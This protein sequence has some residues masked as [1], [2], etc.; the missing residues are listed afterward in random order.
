MFVFYAEKNRLYVME[1]E[2]IT[3]GSANIYPVRFEFSRDWVRA[4]SNANFSGRVQKE[5]CAHRG[6]GVFRARR[7]AV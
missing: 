3:S 5:V 1:K 2:L 7:G 4:V 6:R